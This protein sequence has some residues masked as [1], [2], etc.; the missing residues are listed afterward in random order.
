MAL[1]LVI[2]VLSVV[3]P[4]KSGDV[5]PVHAVGITATPAATTDACAAAMQELAGAQAYY[6]Q[7][8]GYLKDVPLS[9]C[10]WIRPTPSSPKTAISPFVVQ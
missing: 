2:V 5:S 4:V 6:D 10:R 7:F 1:L 3:V 8:P 9:I